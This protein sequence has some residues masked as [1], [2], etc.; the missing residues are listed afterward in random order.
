MQPNIIYYFSNDSD[1]K[2]RKN[3]KFLLPN[4]TI[5]TGASKSEV[6]H[7]SQ[8]GWKPWFYC[9]HSTVLSHQTSHIKQ[10]L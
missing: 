5:I 4:H 2:K 6:F 10:W 7:K 3:R 1:T 9:W 8:E